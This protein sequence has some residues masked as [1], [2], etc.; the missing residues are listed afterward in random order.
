MKFITLSDKIIDDYLKSIREKLK[1]YT[2]NTTLPTDLEIPK[3]TVIKPTISITAL[4]YVKL[5]MLIE[6]TTNEIGFHGTVEKHG[7]GKFLI[8]D[9][10]VYPQKAYPAYINTD[11]TEYG[12]WQAQLP[13]NV[14]RSIR[15]Q[16][17]SHVNM[18]TTPSPTDIT[19]QHDVVR[20][21]SN[22]NDF[23]IFLIVNKSGSFNK[24][25]YD[26]EQNMIFENQDCTLSLVSESGE[27][28]EAWA[29]EEIKNKVTTAVTKTLY[30]GI[31]HN[32]ETK[33]QDLDQA[34]QYYERYY[35]TRHNALTNKK[36]KGAKTDDGL[37]KTL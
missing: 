37:N 22:P 19:H 4:A 25:V 11:E 36:H 34:Y 29:D 24:T 30:T 15:C 6:K 14:F 2:L 31:T 28:I 1:K 33:A 10:Y 13:N 27:S 8:T 26:L 32:T 12:M 7:T 35:T 5:K 18:G 17:H 16:I 21:L 23:Y 9:L 20:L 3:E